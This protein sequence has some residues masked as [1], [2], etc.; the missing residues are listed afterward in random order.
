MSVTD[1]SGNV[2]LEK[3]YEL[4]RDKDEKGEV[5]DSINE[6]WGHLYHYTFTTDSGLKESREYGASPPEQLRV[7]IF[8]SEIETDVVA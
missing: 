1:D 4:A 3:S 8:S 6:L 5:K 7:K 2:V